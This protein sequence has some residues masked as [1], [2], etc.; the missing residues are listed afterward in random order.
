MKRRTLIG[1]GAAL[2]TLPLIGAMAARP[3]SGSFPKGFLW[4]AATSGHQIEGNNVNADTWVVENVKPTIYAERSADAANSFALWPQDLDLVEQIGLNTYR[5]SLEWSRIEPDEG[6]FSIAAMDHYQRIIDGCRERGINPVV[7]F[8]HFTTPRWFAAR[9]GWTKQDAPQLFA[10]YC[11]QAARRLAE[12]IGYATTLNEPNLIAVLRY[13]ALAEQLNKLMPYVQAMN[14]AAA[15]AVGSEQFVTGNTISVEDVEGLTKTMIAG[16][17]AGREA[18]KAVRGNLPV[19][20]SLAI[21]DDQAAGRNSIRDSMR[22][23]LYGAW[24][25][26]VR[27]DDF[28]GVQNYERHIWD[29][30]GTVEP[31][32]GDRN[33]AGGEVYPAALA[34]AVRYAHSVARVPIIVTEHGV[35]T[36]DDALRARFIPAAL[37]E[38]KKVIDEGVPV[39]GYFHWSLIDNFE[40]IYGYKYKYGLASVDRQ[41]FKRTLKPSAQVYGAIARRN[42]LEL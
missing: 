27:G 33:A 1:A 31:P 25:E 10:R 18:I 38:L 17:K 3:R 19:G 39:L 41:T 13:A 42:A 35:N 6:K 21:V 4:G 40:W 37:T 2:A 26:A 24:L 34:G 8:N 16:H 30:K 32:P 7:T 22:T 23:K 20:V 15:R 14:E 11:D 5:F 9:G 28:L 12:G 36:E 29:A